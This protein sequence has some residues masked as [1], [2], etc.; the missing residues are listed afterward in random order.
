MAAGSPSAGNSASGPQIVAIFSKRRLAVANWAALAVS[1]VIFVV[2]A[3]VVFGPGSPG[4]A[5][6]ETTVTTQ[7]AADGQ[8]AGVLDRA[9]DDP[10]LNLLRLA[11]VV[12]AAFLAGAATQRAILGQFAIKLGTFELPGL[13]APVDSAA[14]GLDELKDALIKQAR[15][16]AVLKSEV[17]D[18]RQRLSLVEQARPLRRGQGGGRSVRRSGSL[19][20]EEANL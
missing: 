8:G 10:T 5:T 4:P 16:T 20:G 9:F 14:R 12:L 11:L 18:V 1:V 13:A 7:G 15:G 2:G 3:L 17:D 6:S 19:G